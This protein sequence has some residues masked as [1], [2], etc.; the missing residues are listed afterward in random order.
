MQLELF[1]QMSELKKYSIFTRPC[2]IGEYVVFYN[3]TKHDMKIGLGFDSVSSIEQ[4]K[5]KIKHF[6]ESL[7]LPKYA[8]EDKNDY[9][10]TH[11]LIVE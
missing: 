11:L 8:L 9:F 7:Y 10:F 1:I 5:E 4:V 2:K 6:K 3:N